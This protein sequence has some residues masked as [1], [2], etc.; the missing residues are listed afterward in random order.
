MF[1]A[2]ARPP[3]FVT[4]TLTAP[5][6][7]GVTAVSVVALTNATFAAGAPPKVAVAPA[8]NPVPMICTA[9]PPAAGPVFG[10][11]LATVGAVGVGG[12]AIDVVV[13]VGGGVGEVP[14]PPPPPPQPITPA[15]ASRSAAMARC[16]P[17]RIDIVICAL[18]KLTGPN[19]FILLNKT[20]ATLERGWAHGPMAVES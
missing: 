18:R 11:T 6:P 9:V 12:G 19:R 15:V 20:V 3:G 5:D 17:F 1:S 2:P 14:V 4:T 16:C 7:G 10:D 8:K 13:V